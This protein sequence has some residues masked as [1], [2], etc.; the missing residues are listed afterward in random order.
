[1]ENGCVP[2]LHK[3]CGLAWVPWFVERLAAF[4]NFRQSLHKKIGRSG[5]TIWDVIHNANLLENIEKQHNNK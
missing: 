4:E 1:M 3:L 5:G 2:N